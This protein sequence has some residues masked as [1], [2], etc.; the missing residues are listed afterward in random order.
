MSVYHEKKSKLG[1]K[2]EIFTDKE[3][4]KV[5]GL[6]PQDEIYIIAKPGFLI[7]KK[8]PTL[9]ELLSREPL[10]SITPEEFETISEELQEEA[11]SKILKDISK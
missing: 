2:G 7:I 9:K 6:K 5:V 10:A 8:I 3:I 4:R 11:S 1:K